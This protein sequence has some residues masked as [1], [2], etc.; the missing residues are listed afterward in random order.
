MARRIVFTVD[1]SPVGRPIPIPQGA[2]DL[3]IFWRGGRGGRT[4]VVFTRNGR[5]IGVPEFAPAQANDFEFS[6]RP[7]GGI[8]GATWTRDGEPLEPVPVPEGANDLHFWHK[9]GPG[10]QRGRIVRAFWTRNRQPGQ[11]IPVPEGAN[12]LHFS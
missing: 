8:S 10:G 6:W 5:P 9:P 2:N 1:G 12:D 3:H 4:V 7:D 11:E